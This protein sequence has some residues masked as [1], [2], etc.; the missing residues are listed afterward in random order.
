MKHIEIRRPRKGE[1]VELIEFFN[2]VIKD[3]F[4]KEGIGHLVKDMQDEINMK[5]HFLNA[6]FESD[7]VLRHFL[8]AC[9]GNQ[10]IGTI[11]FGPASSLITKCTNGLFANLYEVGTIFVHPQFQGQGIA[12]QLLEK[13][14]ATLK[15]KGIEEFCLDSGYTMAQKIWTKKFGEPN[16]YLKDY[17]GKGAHH[18]I[19]KVQVLSPF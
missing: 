2:T 17:W 7:G 3:T 16:Y 13:M 4:H 8:I 19:W 10:I 5:A 1:K 9:D 18:M 14:F 12:N 6:D 11:E 15:K